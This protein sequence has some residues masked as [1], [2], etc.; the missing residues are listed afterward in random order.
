MKK[1]QIT[2]KSGSLNV[3]IEDGDRVRVELCSEFFRTEKSTVYK[4]W[5]PK[6]SLDKF[7]MVPKEI[8]VSRMMHD[9]NVKLE[10]Y[11]YCTKQSPKVSG[12]SKTE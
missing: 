9:F 7:G 3:F 12:L 5:V 1:K 11:S 2:I 10:Y 8:V 6:T 4:F